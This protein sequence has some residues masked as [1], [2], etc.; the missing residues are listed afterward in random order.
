MRAARYRGDIGGGVS[1]LPPNAESILEA[2]TAGSR[3]IGGDRDARAAAFHP[4]RIQLPASLRRPWH[5]EYCLISMAAYFMT[6]ECRSELKHA[7]LVGSVGAERS[8]DAVRVRSR[9]Q[10]RSFSWLCDFSGFGPACRS[11]EFY[12]KLHGHPSTREF[13]TRATIGP[14][15]ERSLCPGK[16]LLAN[17]PHRVRAMPSPP[18]CPCTLVAPRMDVLARASRDLPGV[19]AGHNETNRSGDF[20]SFFGLD[21]DPPRL[22]QSKTSTSPRSNWIYETRRCG[23]GI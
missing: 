13:C 4:G 16:P 20:T 7:Q 1:K 12:R 14:C 9:R 18:V 5:A 17:D 8:D 21:G 3:L 10:A 11:D 6:G 19:A 22:V 23:S 15:P 2:F